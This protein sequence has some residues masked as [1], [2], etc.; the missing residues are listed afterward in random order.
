MRKKLVWLLNRFS[1]LMGEVGRGDRDYF[2]EMFVKKFSKESFQ[3]TVS[4]R[5]LVVQDGQFKPSKMKKLV[6][7][8]LGLTS[9]VVDMWKKFHINLLGVVVTDFVEQAETKGNIILF[10]CNPNKI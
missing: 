7:V 5:P 8:T 3:C 6:E 9:K 2:K 1:V 10:A 4:P